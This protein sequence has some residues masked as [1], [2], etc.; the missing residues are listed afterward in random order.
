MSGRDPSRVGVPLYC[1]SRVGVPLYCPSA[2]TADSTGTR[3][4]KQVNRFHSKSYL[5]HLWL[6]VVTMST[7]GLLCSL[8]T[9]H[10]DLCFDLYF[11]LY[12]Y[13]LFSLYGGYSC[14][15]LWSF[16]FYCLFHFIT[17]S[18]VELSLPR[19]RHHVCCWSRSPPP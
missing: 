18:I 8:F 17:L 13:S 12:F 6:V 9:F 14:F 10:F 7:V 4:A 15:V 5:N 1:P 11:D 3:N 16:S 19:G 2:T